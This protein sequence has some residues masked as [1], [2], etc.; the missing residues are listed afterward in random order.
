MKFKRILP[1]LL[2]IILASLMISCASTKA[3]ATWR[4][5]AYEGPP[6]KVI[7]MLVTGKPTVKRL[8]EN[9]FGKQLKARGIDAVPSYKKLPL[10][11]KIE[12]DVIV[13]AL[14]EVNADA[15]FITSLIDK[16]SYETYYPGS[17]YVAAPGFMGHGWDDYYGASFGYYSPGY[18]YREELLYVETQLY[19]MKNE[20]LVWSIM[21]K[22]FVSDAVESK[23]RS[24]VNVITRNLEKNEIVPKKK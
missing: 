24:V 15:I 7:V 13:T 21:T 16:K 2:M 4:D 11:K 6:R 9:E 20:L 8:F 10:D 23:I 1:A 5:D 19:I 12:K 14:N 18:V 17:V 22:T 3:T